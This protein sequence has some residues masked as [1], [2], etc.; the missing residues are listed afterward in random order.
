MGVIVR[1]FNNTDLKSFSQKRINLS[2]HYISKGIIDKGQIDVFLSHSSDDM[3]SVPSVISFLESFGV[4]VYIDKKDNSLPKITSIETAKILKERIHNCNKFIV[5]VSENSKDSRWV[6]WE[7][8][9]A[10][11]NKSVRNIALM[12]L[13][14]SSSDLFYTQTWAEQEYLGIYHRIVFGG[15]KGKESDVWMVLDKNENIG[16]ELIKWLRR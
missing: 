8:G 15:L 10:D 14:N 7:L 13:I 9:L 1:Y 4:N 5:L 11:E 12:P 6:P 3:D 2:E 16:I